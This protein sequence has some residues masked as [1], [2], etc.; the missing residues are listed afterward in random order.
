MA[1][2]FRMGQVE[3]V[4][5]GFVDW[6]NNQTANV[7]RHAVTVGDSVQVVRAISD[8]R[9]VT[10][11]GVVIQLLE[12]GVVVQH[13]HFKESYRFTEVQKVMCRGNVD[14]H[15]VFMVE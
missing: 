12:W 15:N 2:G 3:P 1:L 9:S 13:T 10:R 4:P 11:T 14:T 7:D 8:R 6:G 5:V